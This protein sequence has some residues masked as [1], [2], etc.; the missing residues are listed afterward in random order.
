[1]LE[2]EWRR[3]RLDRAAYHAAPTTNVFAGLTSEYALKKVYELQRADWEA[4]GC[5]EQ[6]PVCLDTFDPSAMY[7]AERGAYMLPCMHWIH[8]GRCLGAYVQSKARE[9][10]DLTEPPST[11][12]GKVQPLPCPYRCPAPCTSEFDKV[13]CATCT[14]LLSNAFAKR[15][16]DADADELGTLLRD[17]LLAVV[18]EG[19]IAHMVNG[20]NAGKRNYTWLK[21]GL[22]RECGLRWNEHAK[23]Y[24]GAASGPIA[25]YL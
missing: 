12:P 13:N 5:D 19:G 4:N 6:C 14:K 9:C 7:D 24:E 11:Q 25:R 18:V 1:V 2:N 10:G 22:F 20:P 21:N 8:A 17:G 23:R 15:E 16:R 3:R